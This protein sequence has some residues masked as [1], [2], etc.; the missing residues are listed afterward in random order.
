MARF[1]VPSARVRTYQDSYHCLASNAGQQTVANCASC[2]GVHNIFPSRD[3]RSTVN[4]ANLGA[5]CGKCH[6]DAGQRFTIGMVHTL[7]ATT[8]GGRTLNFVKAFYLLAIPA[9]LGFMILH[10]LLD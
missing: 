9:I 3:P 7:P 8:A 6:P 5:T 4:K 1:N 10:N 2:H